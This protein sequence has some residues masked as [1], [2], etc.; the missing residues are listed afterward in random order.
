MRSRESR[1]AQEAG[2]KAAGSSE[3][4][5]QHFINKREE[6]LMEPVTMSLD[7]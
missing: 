6:D 1:S 5:A 7:A 3:A 2:D 4:L